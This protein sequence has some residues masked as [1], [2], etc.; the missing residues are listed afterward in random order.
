MIRRPPRST[1]FPYTTLFR[2]PTGPAPVDAAG[3]VLNVPSRQHI[4]EG[5][6][7][8][9]PTHR[10]AQR[11]MAL[12]TL[13]IPAHGRPRSGHTGAVRAQ[14]DT[15]LVEVGSTHSAWACI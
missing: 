3:H 12:L 6:Q 4:A 5:R 9:I 11:K 13:Q 14:M 10:D 1:L 7:H 8:A 2:S 15:G